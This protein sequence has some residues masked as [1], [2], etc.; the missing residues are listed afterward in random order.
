MTHEE[1]ERIK[2]AEKARL[3]ARKR[4]RQVLD[5]LKRRG[6]LR[7]TV[8]DMVEE[9]NRLFQRHDALVDALRTATARTEARAEIALEERDPLRDTDEALREEQAAELVRQYKQA[10]RVSFREPT[11][12]ASPVGGTDDEPDK[13]IGR[14]REPRDKEA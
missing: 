6:A 2:E 1:Y 11:D 3:R 10:E 7:D 14:M 13:T 12:D 5:A 8:R 4:H 9:T